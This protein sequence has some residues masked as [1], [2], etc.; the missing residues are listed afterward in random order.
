VRSR[1]RLPDAYQATTA[2]ASISTG[3]RAGSSVVSLKA[4]SPLGE[5]VATLK[6]VVDS[7]TVPLVSWPVAE[8]LVRSCK[9]AAVEQTHRETV[10]LAL[11]SGP[12]SRRSMTSSTTSRTS[13]VD[14]RLPPWRPSSEVL[15]ST[16]HLPL[17]DATNAVI[18]WRLALSETPGPSPYRRSST[19]FA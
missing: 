19:G 18:L 1:Y 3:G 10:T 17:A 13:A 12:M 8:S 7:A 5:A 4:W 14:A 6:V 11:K 2:T 15:D 9:V 16:A